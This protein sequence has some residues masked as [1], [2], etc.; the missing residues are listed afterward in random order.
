MHHDL[1]SKKSNPVADAY[2]SMLDEEK[3]GAPFKKKADG[4]DKDD[5]KKS[6]DQ[7][8]GDDDS[9]K[10]KDTDDKSK[11]D[12]DKDSDKD[13]DPKDKKSDDES[14]DGDEDA[15]K[16]DDDVD[17]KNGIKDDA[18]KGQN[19]E[20]DPQN[21]DVQ[22]DGT[23]NPDRPEWVP[24]SI[25]DDDL[26]NF[27]NAT[28]SALE[29]G[30]AQF[31]WGGR[32]FLIQRKTD[33]DMNKDLDPNAESD[34]TDPNGNPVNKDSSKNKQQN[35]G[36]GS[37]AGV[38]AAARAILEADYQIPH[39][40]GESQPMDPGTKK[41]IDWHRSIAKVVEFPGTEKQDGSDKVKQAEKP[42]AP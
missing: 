17:P 19:D 32:N 2:L 35:F 34:E 10:S 26:S 12:S 25:A 5:D 15:E 27:I 6:D 33:A 41:M 3:K 23:I 16:G 22:D 1:F 14:K 37:L 38:Q 28:A 30:K 18:E 42:K 7:T 24:D 13:S 29:A 4:D 9:K 36:E 39:P 31:S 8:D 11:D 40:P 20:V 21:P